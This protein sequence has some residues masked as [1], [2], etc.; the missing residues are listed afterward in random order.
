[1][2]YMP[3]PR[4]ISRK[5]LT[6]IIGI[7]VAIFIAISSVMLSGNAQNVKST[8]SESKDVS[9]QL[10]Q[11]TTGHIQPIIS[12]IHELNNKYSR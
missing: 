10:I 8:D 9:L 6:L 5:T 11:K 12:L 3:D 1:M 2:N 7:I 4:S